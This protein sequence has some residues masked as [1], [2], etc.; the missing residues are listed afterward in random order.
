MIRILAQQIYVRQYLKNIIYKSIIIQEMIRVYQ[1]ATLIQKNR[2]VL[3]SLSSQIN[4][5]NLYDLN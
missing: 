4:H 3:N 5:E 2:V 1:K